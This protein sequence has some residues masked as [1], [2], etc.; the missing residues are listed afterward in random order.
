MQKNN[1]PSFSVPRFNKLSAKIKSALIEDGLQDATIQQANMK[2]VLDAIVSNLPK[3]KGLSKDDKYMRRKSVTS[4]LSH[5]I[6]T[7]LDVLTIDVLC[8]HIAGCVDTILDGELYCQWSPKSPANW[9]FIKV[10]SIER[11]FTERKT[12]KCRLESCGG[13]T[14][15]TTWIVNFSSKFVYRILKACGTRWKDEHIPE[16]LFDL[17]LTAKIGYKSYKTTFTDIYASNSQQ[18]YNKNILKKRIGPCIQGLTNKCM[19][20]QLPKK[21]CALSRHTAEYPKE[22]C[23]NTKP[24]KHYGY[25]VRDKI[26]LGCINV[27]RFPH[28]EKR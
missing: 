8:K 27:G 7:P 1:L 4:I 14:Y 28:K 15:G 20:C 17:W 19:N 21:L 13:N 24:T 23:K 18:V 16:D 10:I 12:Y 26:C 5:Y 6:G 3:R 9:A 11:D 22:V 25:I 2:R